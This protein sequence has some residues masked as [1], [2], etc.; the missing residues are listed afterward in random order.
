MNSKSRPSKEKLYQS[1]DTNLKVCL[2]RLLSF[3][4]IYVG[5]KKHLVATLWLVTHLW[6]RVG[7]GAACFS[8][9]EPNGDW[10]LECEDIASCCLFSAPSAPTLT[11]LPSRSFCASTDHHKHW[12]LLTITGCWFSLPD[13]I[14]LNGWGIFTNLLL[15]PPRM[16]ETFICVNC[17][18]M[19]LWRE[20]SVVE[21]WC[22]V[23]GLWW[24]SAQP[25]KINY[26]YQELYL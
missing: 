9:L 21:C 12:V 25:N 24:D 14:G 2:W 13:G 10:R 23:W 26:C 22:W 16:Q 18:F 20:I 11:F 19:S 4:F 6:P 3:L 1:L 7:A 8:G 15:F 17:Y 5:G